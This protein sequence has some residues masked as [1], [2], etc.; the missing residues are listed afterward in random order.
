MKNFLI[1][2]S[3]NFHE[4][5]LNYFLNLSRSILDKIL[6]S[7][8]T[9]NRKHRD[10]SMFS[11]P[12]CGLQ[13]VSFISKF[14]SSKLFL[15]LFLIYFLKNFLKNFLKIISLMNFLK[16][17]SLKYFSHE[18]FSKTFSKTFS[19]NSPSNRKHRD[20]PMFSPPTCGL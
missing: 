15:N 16:I 3:D 13:S 17:I 18:I 6:H 10:F 9:L 20:F 7:L 2:F 11:P 14:I 8:F 12:T 5:F 1:Y 4:T 19:D